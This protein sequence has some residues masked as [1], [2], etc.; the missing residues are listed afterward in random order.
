MNGAAR[1]LGMA[2]STLEFRIK[3]L[4]IDK[5]RYRESPAREYA[6]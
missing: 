5:F 6:N 1:R 2:A 4:G 3:R